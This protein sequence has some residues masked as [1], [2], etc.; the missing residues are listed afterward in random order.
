MTK[1]F[2]GFASALS[3]ITVLGVGVADVSAQSR[4]RPPEGREA[5]GRQAERRPGETQV[6]RVDRRNVEQT[7]RRLEQR[8]DAFR[9]TVD[10]ELDRSRINGS[11]RE[12]RIN[13]QVKQLENAFDALRSE[14]NRGDRFDETRSQVDRAMRQS[15]EV[16]TLFR[17]SNFGREAE[18]E[19]AGIRG[20][21]NSLAAAYNLRP[22][23]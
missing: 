19:W 4:R 3:V 2:A 7:I 10:R 9:K 6:G 18:R 21:L 11:R 23:R 15:D 20:D 13:E 1:T 5:E 16:N 22:L 14:F 17:R 12:D 8:S